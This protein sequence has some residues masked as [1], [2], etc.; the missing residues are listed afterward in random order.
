FKSGD[1]L[2]RVYKLGIPGD[3]YLSVDPDPYTLPLMVSLDEQR[4]A[5]VLHLE[6]NAARFYKYHSGKVQLLETIKS[7]VPDLSLDI[8]RPNKVQRHNYDHL[9]RHLK[10]A[11]AK[12]TTRSQKLGVHDLVLIG[13]DRILN[14]FQEDCLPNDKRNQV[15]AT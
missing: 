5:L 2:Q 6:V 3:D 9:N 11:C 7:Q 8:S 12:L 1:A 15:I 4:T 10:E 14:I 13:D